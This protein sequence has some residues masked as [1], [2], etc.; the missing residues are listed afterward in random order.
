MRV[1]LFCNSR[2]FA[3][4]S[5]GVAILEFAIVSA[6]F[7][8]LLLGGIFWGLTMW[9]LNT[10]QYASERGARCAILVS[11]E[12]CN[13]ATTFAAEN[14]VGLYSGGG[15]IVTADNFA[16]NT[17]SAVTYNTSVSLYQPLSI[18]AQYPV[19]CV[20][21]LDT[22]NS[23][24]VGTIPGNIGLISMGGTIGKISYCRGTQ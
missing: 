12:Y 11:K 6:L 4:K 21:T 17:L 2:L 20:N 19:A 16:Y 23:G 10:L 7:F 13:T 14:A 8:M 18:S 15:G 1:Q 24:G 5:S 3:R 9:Q 22:N